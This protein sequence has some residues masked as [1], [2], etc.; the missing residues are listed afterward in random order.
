M[1]R[2]KNLSKDDMTPEALEKAKKQGR[3]NALVLAAVFLLSILLP[4]AYK[5][6]AAILF[7]VP[8]VVKVMNK[9]RKTEENLESSPKSQTY[10]Q[11]KPDQISSTEPYAYKPKDPKDPRRYKPIG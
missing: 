11:P 6:L 4:S 5:P 7:V 2:G 8:F 10:S 3:L 1:L 9:I